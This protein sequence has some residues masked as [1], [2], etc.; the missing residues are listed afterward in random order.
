MKNF[1]KF[2]IRLQYIKVIYL[3]IFN[4]LINYTFI[5]T[6]H[7]GKAWKILINSKKQRKPRKKNKKYDK[8]FL[9]QIEKE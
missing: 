5:F 6:V 3:E 1:I 8:T 2:L 9:D 7:K 4:L